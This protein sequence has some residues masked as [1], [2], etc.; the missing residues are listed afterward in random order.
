M[1]LPFCAPPSAESRRQYQRHKLEMMK[2]WRD[3][4][5]A[6]LAALNAAISTVEQQIGQEGE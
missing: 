1:F 4:L 6:H 2:Y 3:S 5:E